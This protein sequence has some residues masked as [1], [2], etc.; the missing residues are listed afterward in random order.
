MICEKCGGNL[1]PNGE[2]R[3]CDMFA[4]QQPPRGVSD[5][6]R[7]R[8]WTQTGGAQF[9]DDKLRRFYLEEAKKAGIDVSGKQYYSELAAYPGDP[10]A[11]VDSQGEMRRVIEE[12]G[13]SSD[14]DLKVKGPEVERAPDVPIAADLVDD[15][16]E[17][18]LEQQ[19]GPDFTTVPRRDYEDAREAVIDQHAAPAHLRE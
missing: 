16:V 10:R 3:V 1:R 15:L 18:K 17:Q 7:F 4:A 2:C 11:W 9:K 19:F 14:G 8:G 5:D 13:W 6:T 12:R